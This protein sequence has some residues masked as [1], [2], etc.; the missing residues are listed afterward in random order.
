[1]LPYTGSAGTNYTVGFASHRCLWS[2]KVY[3]Y[4]ASNKRHLSGRR[5]FGILEG[6]RSSTSYGYAVYCNT[7]RSYAKVKGNSFWL[8]QHRFAFCNLLAA[9]NHLRISPYISY[10][11]GSVSGCAAT[12][13]SYPFDLLRTILA[14]QGE[15][16]VYPNMRAAL[17]NI[18]ETRGLRG[19]YAGL[20]PTLV[21]IV[22][23]AGLQFGTYDTFRRWTMAWKQ[24]R[25]QYQRLDPGV[26]TDVEVSIC[27]LAAGICAKAVCHPLDVVKKRFQVQGLQRDRRYGARVRPRAYQNIHDAIVQILRSEGSAGLYKGIVPS[28]IKAA[29]ATAV[30]F[31]AFE[32]AS[33]WLRN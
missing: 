6:Q 30:T 25:S 26:L 1:M 33:K 17:F 16:K 8:F 11:S 20:A 27:G 21:E 32:Y 19:L 12:I 5:I 7:V 31:V 18:L 14:S 22:P 29:P 13:G 24:N 3:R 15:P 10:I 23:Y 4:A 9:E 2:V 28:V